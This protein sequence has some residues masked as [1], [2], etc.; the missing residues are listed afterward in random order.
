MPGGDGTGPMGLGSRTGRGMGYCEGF[1]VPSYAN[2]GFGMGRGRGFRRMYYGMPAGGQYVCYQND[3]TFYGG[4]N[5]APVAD[6][7]EALKNE[8]DY[9][10]K[11]LTALLE[12]LK[13]FQ[14][15]E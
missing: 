4:I 9:L 7:K 12:R 3:P 15:T 1:A 6:E 11:Q 10:E 13:A 14:K 8:V 5:A 2:A